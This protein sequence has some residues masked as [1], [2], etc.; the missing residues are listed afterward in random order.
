MTSNVSSTLTVNAAGVVTDA[1]IAV[2]SLCVVFYASG[3]VTDTDVDKVSS[4]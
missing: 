4:L 2:N 3:N 1:D